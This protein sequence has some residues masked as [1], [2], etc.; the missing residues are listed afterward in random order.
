MIHGTDESEH[1]KGHNVPRPHNAL[2]YR[3]P[4]LEAIRVQ[5]SR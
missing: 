5:V 3:P 1:S 2:D 4:V